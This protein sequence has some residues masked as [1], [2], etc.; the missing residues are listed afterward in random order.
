MDGGI[1][2]LLAHEMVLAPEP[3]TLITE[4]ACGL[5]RTACVLIAC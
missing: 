5:L 4:T 1:S 2:L 3:H